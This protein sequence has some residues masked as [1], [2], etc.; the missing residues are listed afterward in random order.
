MPTAPHPITNE[1]VP[2]TIGHE[3][4]GI[5][6]EA[7]NEIKDVKPGDRVVV[8]PIIYDGTCG[9]CKDGYINCCDSNGFVGLSGRSP[10]DC[11]NET[12]IHGVGWG[13]GISE[14]VVVPRY[15]VH[16]IPENISLEVGGKPIGL[17]Y[18]SQ[19]HPATNACRTSCG[20]VARGQKQSFQARGFRTRAWS[21][22]DRARR[23]PST[24]SKRGRESDS[25][26]S[27][28]WKKRICRAFWSRLGIRPYQG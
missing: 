12:L 16:H 11:D 27:G 24:E 6:E 25:I 23:H 8:Q 10:S 20:C 26:R 18:P 14:H 5:V 7:G 2:L 3:F 21:W 22:T 15:A 28:G 9:A 4:S 19:A 13:G 17:Q 1:M